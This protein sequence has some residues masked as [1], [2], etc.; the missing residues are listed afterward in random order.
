MNPD[1][2][3]SNLFF[4]LKKYIRDNGESFNA[5]QFQLRKSPRSIRSEISRWD[6]V[7]LSQPDEAT[8]ITLIDRSLSDIQDIRDR[9][10]L[11][12]NVERFVL[13]TATAEEIQRIDTT[14][15]VIGT[16]MYNTTT[17]KIVAFNGNNWN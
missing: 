10:I 4:A 12:A 17:K 5:S 16:I 11:R 14:D 8:L 7:S 2:Y 9:D 13:P 1:T 6:Y 15:L 3:N